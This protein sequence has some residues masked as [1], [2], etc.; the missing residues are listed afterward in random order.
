MKNLVRVT[1]VLLVFLPAVARTEMGALHIY[2]QFFD[3]DIPQARVKKILLPVSFRGREIAQAHM[4]DTMQVDVKDLSDWVAQNI[5]DAIAQ[6]IL[7][8][9]TVMADASA[10]LGLTYDAAGAVLTLNPEPAFLKK[11]NIGLRA[12]P[13]AAGD[14]VLR[15]APVSAFVNVRGGQDVVTGGAAPEGR[16]PL[17]LD[18]DGAVNVR[19]WVLEGRIDYLE[20]APKS[21]ARGDMRLVH[22]MPDKMVR[23]AAGDLSYPVSGFQSYQP[24]LGVS[25]ARNFSLQPYRVTVPTG[26]TSFTLSSPARVEVLVNGQRTRTLR[27]EPGSYD[28]SDFPVADG[29]NDVTLLITDSTGRTETRRFSLFSDQQLLQKGLNEYSYN[30]GVLSQTQERQIEYRANDPAISFFHRYGFTD[31]LTAGMSAQGSRESAQAGLT[32]LIATAAGTFGGETSVSR[33]RDGDTDT[34]ARG[35]YRLTDPVRRRD[36]SATAIWRSA[37][38]SALGL[39]PTLN[40]AAVELAARYN[41]PVWNDITLGIGGRYK[42]SRSDMPDDWSYSASL[43]RGFNAS[44]SVNITA[45]H[46]YR[47]GAGI[48]LALT[49]TPPLSRHNVS[50]SIDTLAGRQ[51]VQWNYRPNRDVGSFRYNAGL[52]HNNDGRTEMIGEAAYTG[53]RGE[54]SLRHDVTELPDVAETESRSQILFGSALVYADGHAAFSRPV[55]GSF[56]MLP[57]HPNL[58]DRIIGINRASVAQGDEDNYQAQIDRLGPAVISDATAYMYRP[59]RI[60]TQNLPVGYDLGHDAFTLMPSYKSGTVLQVGNAA[61]IFADGYL[62]QADGQVL[63]LEGGTIISTDQKSQQEFFTNAEGRFRISRLSPGTYTVTLHKY[64]AAQAMLKIPDIGIGR[65]DAGKITIGEL[66]P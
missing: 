12:V 16:Q 24:M 3:R 7:H 28:I 44:I 36:F 49:W 31:R 39:A 19:D 10:P 54:A 34:A 11:Q 60:D 50:S 14:T 51:D 22:D 40:P 23:L 30:F 26:E 9:E 25:V 6:K 1:A 5:E 2:R 48:F 61:N 13:V 45:E 62:Q 57:R 65:F 35:S 52:S 33:R 37:H 18:L 8:T 56:V 32:A 41:Q 21:I 27:L 47:D 20:D 29:G 53:Y 63:A 59:V 38:F 42:F 58:K 15:P 4:N 46:R 17:R 55:N 43:S 64:P 66:S